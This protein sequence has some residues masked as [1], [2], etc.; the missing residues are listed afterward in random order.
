MIIVIL[1]LATALSLVLIP[2][3]RWISFRTGKVAVPRADR[4]HRQPTPT[5]GGVGMFGASALALCFFALLNGDLHGFNWTLVAASIGMFLLGLIDDFFRLSPPIKLIAQMSFSTLIIFFGGLTIRFFPWPIFNILLTY[6]WLIGIT[7][8]INLLDNMDGIAGGVAMIAAAFLAIFFWRTN[9]TGLLVLSFA[10]IGSILGFLIFNFPPAR[11]FMGDSG[12]MFLGFTLASLA[13]ARSMQASNVFS[14]MAVP[15]MIF[16]APILD[17]TLVTVT[18]LLRGQSPSQGGTDHST[19]RLVAFGLNTRQ[20]V[21]VMYIVSLLGG[22]SGMALE[23]SNYRIS[24]VLVPLILIAL[25]LLTAYLG[26]AKVVTTTKSIVEERGFSRLVVDLTYRRRLFEILLDLVLISFAYYVGY[27]TRYGLNMTQ[28]SMGFFLRSWPAALF[29]GYV[30]FYLIGVYRNVW[31]RFYLMDILRYLT[32]VC[33]VTIGSYLGLILVDRSGSYPEGAFVFFAL[34]L[35]LGLTG[36]RAF[37][38]LLDRMAA[39]SRLNAVEDAVYFYGAGDAGEL[40]LRW[41]QRLPKPPFRPIAVFDEDSHLWGR[42][43]YNLEIIGGLDK[44]DYQLQKK[45]V[46]GV[47][48]TDPSTINEAFGERL[49][50]VCDKH[51]VWI[52]ILNIQLESWPS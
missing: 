32:A 28:E 13:I 29:V 39:E 25:T 3:V 11:I 48:V 24:L 12:S 37:F 1:P 42:S 21:F 43:F 15:V 47:V 27:W 44:L 40:A 51:G 10:L 49:K 50:A 2:V 6:F 7:N 20:V 41:M 35:F 9:A 23:A 17:T 45:N 8:A 5:L 34:Y 4:W 22:A 52:K 19:H 33:L 16:L 18:R 30:V 31:G 36:S 14:V 46:I 38:V 26:R